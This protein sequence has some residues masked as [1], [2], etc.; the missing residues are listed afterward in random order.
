MQPFMKSRARMFY[1]GLDVKP[2]LISELYVMI[3]ERL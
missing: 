1:S 2:E 3:S